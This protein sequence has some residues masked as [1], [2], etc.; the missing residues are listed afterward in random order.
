[1]RME[2]RRRGPPTPPLPEPFPDTAVAGSR[3]HSLCCAF[4]EHRPQHVGPLQQL[5]GRTVESDLTLLHEVGRL[6]NGERDV[7]RLLD[8]DDRRALVADRFDD[9]K[10]LLDD[11]RRQAE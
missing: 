1:M 10:H 4:E 6:G 8:E 5:V 9:R 3:D 7:H 11:D 2:A